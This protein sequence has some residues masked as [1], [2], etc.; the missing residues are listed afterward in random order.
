MHITI[1][2]L[3]SYNRVP[4]KNS[5]IYLGSKIRVTLLKSAALLI[6]VL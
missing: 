6:T 5:I 2:Q 3:D 1:I 4:A